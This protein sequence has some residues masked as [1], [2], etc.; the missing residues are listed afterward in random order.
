MAGF[1]AGGRAAGQQL[2]PALERAQR[3]NPGIATRVVHDHVDARPAGQCPGLPAEILLGV[4]DDIVSTDLAELLALILGSSR[5]DDA[6]TEHLRDLDAGDPDATARPQYQDEIG[7]LDLAN[8]EQHPDSCAVRNRHG[9]GR[10]EIQFGCKPYEIFSRNANIFRHTAWDFLAHHAF[11]R[12]RVQSHTI[13]KT[14]PIHARAE[15][16]DFADDVPTR[17]EGHW[18]W[19]SRH[20]S[21]DK[22]IEMIETA[23]PYPKQHLVLAW[24]RV[25]PIAIHQVLEPPLLLNHS[26]FHANVPRFKRRAVQ[27]HNR[28]ETIPFITARGS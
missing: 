1:E 22:D 15:R 21:A 23:S 6:G 5:C 20:P 2:S 11:L 14:P 4:V 3:R 24:D 25:R 17:Y 28:R 13:A 8:L 26:C 18:H 19:K 7:G 27:D 10:Y 12:D 16:R 9:G